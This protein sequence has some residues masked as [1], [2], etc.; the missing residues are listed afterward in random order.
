MLERLC[1]QHLI[2]VWMFEC[3]IIQNLSFG[4]NF[5]GIFHKIQL[6]N[7]CA[8][9]FKVTKFQTRIVVSL[10][11]QLEQGCKA[12]ELRVE[13]DSPGP[14]MELEP[15][16]NG[17][18]QQRWSQADCKFP[19]DSSHTPGES[20]KWKMKLQG[21]RSKDKSIV[22]LLSDCSVLVM[23]QRNTLRVYTKD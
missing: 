18:G 10:Q 11:Q 1:P 19:G 12:K 6:A 5:Y 15:K 17:F 23:Q 4:G 9:P 13:S 2:H 7:Q 16:S 22:D 20:P 21:Q 8:Q 3:L 14:S